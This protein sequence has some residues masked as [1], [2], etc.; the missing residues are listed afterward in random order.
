MRNKTIA[1]IKPE[2][3]ILSDEFM[4]R[5]AREHG[6]RFKRGKRVEA[7]ANLYNMFALDLIQDYQEFVTIIE[8]KKAKK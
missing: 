8:R 5:A 7:L 6:L 2:L 3:L 4:R 1:L